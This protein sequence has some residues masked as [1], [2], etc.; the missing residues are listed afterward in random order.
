MKVRSIKRGRLY[1]LII[2]SF[3]LIEE[4]VRLQIAPAAIDRGDLKFLERALSIN[5][6]SAELNYRVGWVYRNLLLGDDKTIERYFVT[7]LEKSPLLPSS[8]L[9]LSEL[10]LD[11]GENKKSLTALKIARVLAPMSPARLWQGAIVAVRLNEN[12]MALDNLRFV[13][14]ADVSKRNAVY[15]LA[16]EV[17][18]D[19]DTILDRVVSNQDL[20]YYL[21]Y[22]VG[23]NKAE[24]APGVWEKVKETDNGELISDQLY[25]QYIN[26]LIHRGMITESQR[27]WND[28]MGELKGHNLVWN[29]GFEDEPLQGAFG[30]RLHESKGFQFEYDWK[31]KVAGDNALVVEFDGS[32]NLDFM[33]LEQIVPVRVNTEYVFRAQLSSEELSTDNGIIWEIYCRA[34]Y[35]MLAVTD[36][37]KG[38]VDWTRV[39]ATF[40]TPGDC[41]SVVLR[42]RRH[43]SNKFDKYIAG[44]LWVD[45]INLKTKENTSY[46]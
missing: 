38:T 24:Y 10:Y 46:D 26:S 30:W 25:I 15:D 33:H 43:K 41:D 3:F 2:L 11:A 29:G 39:G 1:L 4:T 37:I 23:Y 36:Q 14:S 35:K 6:A 8:W 34:N 18:G 19:P 9:E 22:L 5:P 7:A 17:F 28:R 27:A 16:W 20:G 40:T 45:D 32:E 42:L 13:A 31:N 21:A 12:D 44:K